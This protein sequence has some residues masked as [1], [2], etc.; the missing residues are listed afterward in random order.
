MALAD[1]EI[2]SNTSVEHMWLG[3]MDHDG[4][5]IVGKITNLF[6]NSEPAVRSR[7]RKRP[8]V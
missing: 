1:G 6:R 2:V 8:G 3:E 5:S 7:P 4:R